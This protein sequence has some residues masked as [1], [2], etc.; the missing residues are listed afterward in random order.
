MKILA[1]D[2]GKFNTMCAFSI[3]KPARL[4]CSPRL[5]TARRIEMER[6]I[7][8]H[9]AGK[10]T[11]A[12]PLKRSAEKHLKLSFTDSSVWVELSSK[13]DLTPI[14]LRGTKTISSLYG[15]RTYLPGGKLLSESSTLQVVDSEIRYRLCRNQRQLAFQKLSEY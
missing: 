8:R 9:S 13:V 14:F 2:L 1:L 12:K 10:P 11:M 4:N 3:P 5:P 6:I 15:M 7:A